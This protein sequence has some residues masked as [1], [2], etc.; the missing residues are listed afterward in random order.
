MMFSLK[1]GRKRTPV[2]GARTGGGISLERAWAVLFISAAAAMVA[3]ALFLYTQLGAYQRD[4][5]QRESATLASSFARQVA[6]ALHGYVATVS[7]LAEDPGVVR[8]LKSG[9]ANAIHAKENALASLFPSA[10]RVRLLPPGLDAPDESAD[11]PVGYACLDLLHQAERTRKTPPVEVHK[12]GSPQQH[13]S[14]ARA[15]FDRDGKLVGDVLVT[16]ALPVLQQALTNLPLA[17]GS[18]QLR[19]VVPGGAPL[20]IAS[21]GRAAPAAAARTAAVQGTRWQLLYRPSAAAGPLEGE[22]QLLYWG[23]FGIALVVVALVL[24]VVYRMLARALQQDQVTVIR[25]V[26]DMSEGA[27]AGQYPSRLGNCRGTIEQLQHMARQHKSTVAARPRGGEEEDLFG[28][29]GLSTDALEVEEAP[30]E[31]EL[32]AHIFRAYDIRGVVGESLDAH[33][34]EQIGRAIGSEA[35]QRGLE[36]VIVARDGR[37]SGDE[38]SVALIKGLV[39]SGREVI[40]IGR[41]P[42][43]VLYFATHYL[44]GGSGVM[45]T[46][47]HNPPDY[48]GFKIMLG[49]ETL[50]DE[51]IQALRHR[52]ESGN[53]VSG[54][55][56]VQSLDVVP[57]YVDRIT[58]DVRLGR[59]VKVVVDCGN[60]VTGE[61]APQLLRALGCEVV[62]LYCEVDGNFPN[63]HPD[64]GKPENL[65]ALTR[66]VTEH[67]ADVGVAFDGDGDRLG[68]VDSEGKIIWP[69]RVLMLLAMDVLLRN[70]EAEIIYDVKCSRNLERVISE[71]GGKPLMWKTGHSF[72]KS[73]MKETGALLAGEMSG[74]IFFKERWFGFDDALYA[75]ARLLEI[76]SADM[77]ASSKVFAALPES[78][79]TPELNATMAE[80]EHFALMQRLL[81]N[82]QFGGGKIITLDGLRVEFPDG[83]GLV[84]PSNTTPSLVMRFEA[85]DAEAL[86]RIQDEFREQLLALDP[87]LDLPF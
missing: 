34:T 42:T 58:S 31:P 84:R 46:G 45:L 7:Y 24:L 83:W 40:D 47:S 49:G 10:L 50:H 28:A 60:G 4:A 6:D 37:L 73:K 79:S 82:G 76:L 70:P 77:Q 23:S 19:Q 33:I 80:G 3:L 85:D 18:V 43:P 64:P 52:I 53:L 87:N 57:S 41:V 20:V 2:G 62:E 44:G 72:I 39:G 21:R 86:R 68:V 81:A 59:P 29:A 38:L 51:G 17:G 1:S 16:P 48:N 65:I 30:A 66:A 74:H 63:H 14:I 8:V 69:D 11:P 61:I 9:D 54:E 75:C 15:V 27:L 22:L 56:G 26:R 55:G 78:V 67:E 12:F 36:K 25:L 35:Q 71:N 13:I 32:P 5:A